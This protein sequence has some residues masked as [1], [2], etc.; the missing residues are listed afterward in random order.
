[1][2]KLTQVEFCWWQK[3]TINQKNSACDKIARPYFHFSLT[4]QIDVIIESVFIQVDNWV[5]G[6]Q[7]QA[8]VYHKAPTKYKGQRVPVYTSSKIWRLTQKNICFMF[9]GVVNFLPLPLGFMFFVQCIP[10][11]KIYVVSMLWITHTPKSTIHIMHMNSNLLDFPV[12]NQK[13]ELCTSIPCWIVRFRQTM[14]G[15]MVM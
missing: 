4:S 11:S 14:D 7:I 1:M 9:Y 3:L 5:S 8:K 10:Y 6:Y 2:T 12:V 13:R 15:W